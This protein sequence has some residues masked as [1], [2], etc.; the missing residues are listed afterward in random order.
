MIKK[1]SIV[2]PCRNEEKFILRCLNSIFNSDYPAELIEVLACDGKSDDQTPAIIEEYAKKNSGVR[3]LVNEK[4]TTPNALNLGINHSSGDVIIILG[5]HAELSKNYISECVKI[6]NEKHDVQCV[7]GV[8]QNISE[9]KLAEAISLAM[10]SPFG[11][12]NAH[13]RTGAK[14]GYVDTVAFGAY[15]KEVFSQIGFFDEEL[16][17]NQDDEF[18]FRLLKSGGK[19]WLTTAA[20]ATYYVRS[21]FTKLFKQYFQYGYWKVYVNKKHKTVTTL[22]Q[23]VP[24]AFVLCLYALGIFVILFPYRWEYLALYLFIYFSAAS[25]FAFI[26]TREIKTFFPVIISFFILHLS[27]G[28][29]YVEGFV[30]FILLGKKP[31]VTQSSLTR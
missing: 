26:L 20:S 11:V 25:L 3:Y 8:L 4:I 23:L 31:S 18:N 21:S 6:L 19:I 1:V 24:A 13:F 10:S 28:M 29:G 30:N 27:Y 7:G 5:A 22:R 9:D 2:I 15:R 17:R 14:D 16:V 12:G